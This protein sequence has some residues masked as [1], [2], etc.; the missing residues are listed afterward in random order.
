[1]LRR[2]LVVRAAARAA[3]ADGLLNAETFTRSSK[4]I[5]RSRRVDMRHVLL[6]PELRS[7][8]PRCS[9]CTGAHDRLVAAAVPG[10][11]VRAGEGP[12]KRAR[13]RAPCLGS[14]PRRSSLP[15]EHPPV[16]ARATSCRP[17]RYEGVEG[18]GYPRCGLC[19][20]TASVLQSHPRPS[21]AGCSLQRES[22]W[23]WFELPST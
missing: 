17:V 18:Q 20:Q 5:V 22:S 10:G 9:G 6:A 15:I 19:F 2:T 13:A 1:M 21:R 7:P 12:G 14:V 11:V 3:Y 16:Q 4:P 8:W 23:R